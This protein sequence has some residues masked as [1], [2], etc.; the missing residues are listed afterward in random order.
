MV[1]TTDQ[2]SQPLNYNIQQRFHFIELIIQW[3]G[4][5]TTN[6]LQQHFGI[7]RS[8]ASQLIQDYLALNPH[9]LIYNNSLKGYQASDNF[10][11]KF[12][13]LDLTNYLKTTQAS[14]QDQS[15]YLTWL[16][17][18]LAP[19]QP[20]KVRGVLQALKQK[21]RVDVGYASIASPEFESRIISPHNL[22]FDGTRWHVRAYCEKNQDFR[23]FVLTRFSGEYE[24]EGAAQFD[25]KHDTLWQTH[26]NVIIEPDPRLA[27][28]KARIIALDHQM[29]LQPNGRYQRTLK[30]RAALLL[31][32]LKQ[33]GVVSYHVNPEAQQIILSPECLAQ[34]QP[35]LP[36]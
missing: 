11:P 26:L 23:D 21:L 18:P 14:M 8:N 22:V 24:F 25:Q 9:S 15:K 5:L 4:R 34:L 30:I 10:I 6:H 28:N 29:Q 17:S 13:Q 2:N 3:E 32:L 20:D 31:Y 7:S 33:L 19:I 1:E 36:R 27:Q 35:Y 16:N 12:K